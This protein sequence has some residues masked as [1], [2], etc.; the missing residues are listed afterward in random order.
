MTG[1]TCGC[2]G[3]NPQRLLELISKNGVA[4]QMCVDYSW[5][6]KDNLGCH[7]TVSE[8]NQLI[9]KCGCY[10][11]S[12]KHYLYMI[13][14]ITRTEDVDVIKAHIMNVG[15][16]ISG[17]NVFPNFEAS[18]GNFNSTNGIYIESESYGAKGGVDQT[19]PTGGHAMVILG[20]G[21]A[22]AGKYGN[23]PYWFCRNTWGDRWGN[24]GYTKMAMWPINKKTCLEK[25]VTLVDPDGYERSTGGVLLFQPSRGIKPYKFPKIDMPPYGLLNN[26][27]YYQSDI[28]TKEQAEEEIKK[29]ESEK[30][31]ERM[32]SIII[33]CIVIVGL[34]LSLIISRRRSSRR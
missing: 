33:I 8:L 3:G 22:K 14:G 15:P 26:E 7:G 21:I 16:V 28:L 10:F 5:C 32:F 18:Y 9:P 30:T 20:W 11:P 4:S 2:S 25:T 29:Y 34:I 24:G 31:R 13:E 19:K 1:K 12:D 17:F 23:V 27:D 6:N